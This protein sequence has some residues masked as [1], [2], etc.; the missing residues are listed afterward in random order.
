MDGQRQYSVGETVGH[1]AWV[2]VGIEVTEGSLT[3][4]RDG[5][6]DGR[7]DVL[8]FQDGLESGSGLLV[9]QLDGILRPTGVEPLR[10]NWGDDGT[11][12]LLG[13]TG[14]HLVDVDQ[15]MLAE[16]L[17][18]H[19]EDGRLEAVEAGVHAD[20]HVVVTV[21]SL[22]VDMIGLHEGC[23]LVVVGEHRTAVAVA[24]HGFGGEERGRGDVAEGAGP[25]LSDASS[26]A[27]GGVFK[28]VEMITVGKGTD[29]LEVGRESK[30]V[31]GDDDAGVELAFLEGVL[32]LALQVVHIHVVGDGVDVDEDRRGALHGDDLGGSEEGERGD[33]H[34][35]TGLHIPGLEGEQQGVGSAV[36]C[37]AVLRIDIGGEGILHLL[38]FWSHDIG[39]GLH[40]LGDGLV[41]L[42]LEDRILLFQI[43]ELHS[44]KGFAFVKNRESASRLVRDRNG[45]RSIAG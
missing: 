10:D 8:G 39:A 19:E 1:G 7:G 44:Q 11:G 6:I 14:G 16:S 3:V 33:E 27:L 42:V 38:D 29:G 17:E 36:T 26:E 2:L 34:G 13:V 15:L 43:S 22:A 24:T 20:A 40:H 12:E 21:A 30:E 35:V 31:D 5:V 18:L 28:D 23:P 41:H 45:H 4:H 9:G 32:D 25:L 37:D